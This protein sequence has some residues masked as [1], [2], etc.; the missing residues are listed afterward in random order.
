LKGGT[1]AK[2]TVYLGTRG[3]PS[4]WLRQDYPIFFTDK[5]RDAEWYAF[6]T[7][8]DT[9]WAQVSVFKID[10]R[11]AASYEDLMAAIKETNAVPDDLRSVSEE[12]VGR[13]ETNAVPYA[14]RFFSKDFDGSKPIHYLY[15]P[16]VIQNLKEKGF[17]GFKGRDVLTYT[18][19]PI[20][21]LFD[22]KQAQLVKKTI[23]EQNR[24]REE[25]ARLRKWNR[26]NIPPEANKSD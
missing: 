26:D 5:E 14:I 18:E 15:L 11:R 13:K 3:D 7:G 23:P 1:L 10:L 6:E 4:P 21:V 2:K 17:D 19:V 25:R 8:M 20:T 22:L 16:K 9:F 24:S 12:Y